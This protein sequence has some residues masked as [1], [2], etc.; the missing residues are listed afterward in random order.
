MGH[1][2]GFSPKNKTCVTTETKTETIY[3]THIRLQFFD[4]VTTNNHVSN[5]L[6]IVQNYQL[7]GKNN[8]LLTNTESITLP[9]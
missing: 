1:I 4:K 3:L 9:V 2:K 5:I 7:F 6:L 8:V